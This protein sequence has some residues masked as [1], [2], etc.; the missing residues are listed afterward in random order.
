MGSGASGRG[1]AD[2]DTGAG[3]GA[4]AGAGS[5]SG[6]SGRRVSSSSAGSGPIVPVQAYAAAAAA[7]GAEGGLGSDAVSGERDGEARRR[8]RYIDARP[9]AASTATAPTTIK[10][11]P[12]DPPLLELPVDPLE[13]VAGCAG[14]VAGVEVCS[15]GVVCDV[16]VDVVWAPPW[17]VCEPSGYALVSCLGAGVVEL[18]PPAAADAATSTRLAPRIRHQTTTN[19]RSRRRGLT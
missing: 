15:L 9:A 2:A 13:P 17:I 14:C 5:G 10:I 11:T 4:G 6:G 16:A 12:D 18:E 19:R 3:A 1:G 7:P 8:I